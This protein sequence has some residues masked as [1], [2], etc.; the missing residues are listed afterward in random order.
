MKKIFEASAYDVLRA[1]WE[2]FHNI[3]ISLQEALVY[4]ILSSKQMKLQMLHD[5]Q[6]DW[7]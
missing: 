5:C 4:Q 1:W 7:K 6:D 2:M 3:S